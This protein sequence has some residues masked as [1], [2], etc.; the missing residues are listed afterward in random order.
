MI[1]CLGG[2]E[3]LMRNGDVSELLFN[4]GNVIR[5]SSHKDLLK[6][7]FLFRTVRL[8]FLDTLS[9]NKILYSVECRSRNEILFFSIRH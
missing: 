6:M 4:L 7:L 8:D 2:G 1:L 9:Q 5:E 3:F